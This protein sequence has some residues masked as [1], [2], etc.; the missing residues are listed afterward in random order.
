MIAIALGVTFLALLA[1]LLLGAEIGR[2]RFFRRL[3][4]DRELGAYVL[5]RLAKA[6][7]ARVQMGE[8]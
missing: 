6:H 2:R 7:G 3:I 8:P 5:E 1:G 4:A